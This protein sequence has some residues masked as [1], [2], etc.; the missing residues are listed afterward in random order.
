MLKRLLALS[1]FL[2]SQYQ[3]TQVAL[4]SNETQI[5]D[6]EF[7]SL[8][9]EAIESDS[10]FIDKFDAKVWLFD[11]SSRLNGKASH[12]PLKER[13][14]L[15]KAV[16]RE[17]T[18]TGVDPQLVLSLIEIE[19]SFDHYALSKSG[20]KGLMQVMPFWVNEIGHQKDNLF[21]IDTNL[22]YGCTIL[23]IYLQR[24]N[25]HVNKA[26]A[27]YNGSLGSNRYPNKVLNALRNHWF[28]RP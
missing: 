2:L 14:S 10:G 7:R 6:D 27:S 19:S 21:D 20:A 23:S 11:M 24:H 17:A 16:H 28:V 3:M 4:A 8:L 26:L 5:P 15:L 22:R 13:M 9:K 1:L 25:N 12:I 18:K